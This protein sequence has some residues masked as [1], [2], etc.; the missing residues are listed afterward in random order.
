MAESERKWVQL[1]SANVWTTYGSWMVLHF[2]LGLLLRMFPLHQAG[3]YIGFWGW[4]LLVSL[5]GAGYGA[6]RA[7]QDAAAG[8]ARRP[9]SRTEYVLAAV[10]AV[11]VI[12]IV[13]ATDNTS[14]RMPG[15]YLVAVLVAVL[16]V[17]DSISRRSVASQMRCKSGRAQ[18]PRESVYAAVVTASVVSIAT[19][20]AVV[21]LNS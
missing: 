9:I 13:F 19:S 6:F 12:V 4:F 10:F 21:G 1:L 15:R 8:L 18:A 5:S 7:R 2:G 16:I 11:S 14:A 17:V 20:P 3:D